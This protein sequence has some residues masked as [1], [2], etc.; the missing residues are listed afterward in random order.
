MAAPSTT[1]GSLNPGPADRIRSAL[2]PQFLRTAAARRFLA[3]VLVILAGAAALR[4]DTAGVQTD[5]VTAAVDLQPGRTVSANDLR[6]EKR[7]TATVPDGAMT[8]LEDVAG[9][10]VAGPARRGEIITDAGLLRSRLAGISAGPDARMVGVRLDDGAILEVVRPGDVVD[11]LGAPTVGAEAPGARGVGTAASGPPRVLAAGAIVVGIASS[12]AGM[13][14][15]THRV[16]LVALPAAA[17]ATVA[18]AGLV[19]AMAVTVR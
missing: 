18:A 5:V 7:L 4:P 8:R 2:R 13:G 11:V 17:A 12:G 3:G 14:S 10:A 16:L 9:A 19:A 6:I 15:D 1:S